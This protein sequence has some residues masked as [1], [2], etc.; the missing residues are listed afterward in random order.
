MSESQKMRDFQ[1]NLIQHIFTRVNE[2]SKDRNLGFDMKFS[3]KGWNRYISI[4]RYEEK[5]D[6]KFFT[7]GQICVQLRENGTIQCDETIKLCTYDGNDEIKKEP[8]SA[9]CAD[10]F[11]ELIR[12]YFD[13]NDSDE[14]LAEKFSELSED[15]FMREA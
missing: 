12:L 6:F 7:R 10:L 14:T 8:L 5:L 1:T 2:E 15:M 13:R 11:T 4:Q 9:K 3:R